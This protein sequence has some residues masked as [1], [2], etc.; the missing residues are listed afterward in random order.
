MFEFSLYRS[1]ISLLFTPGASAPLC[2]VSQVRAQPSDVRSPKETSQRHE[3]YL[4][5]F[6]L[7]SGCQAFGTFWSKFINLSY[8]SFAPRFSL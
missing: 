4:P 8:I 2:S 5:T 1:R 3:R 7:Q 6:P